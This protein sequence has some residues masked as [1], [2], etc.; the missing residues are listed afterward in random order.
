MMDKLNRKAQLLRQRW[1]TLDRE[2][3]EARRRVDEAMTVCPAELGVPAQIAGTWTAMGTT[4]TIS[5]S[6]GIIRWTNPGLGGENASGTVDSKTV[7][8]EWR[9]GRFGN[10]SGTGR[11]VFDGNGRAIRIEW[12]N[13]VVFL[14]Q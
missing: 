2:A 4:Y 12:S 10:G 11:I 5:Q 6:G 14:R 1:E 7:R 8:A 3:S 9:G 13:G